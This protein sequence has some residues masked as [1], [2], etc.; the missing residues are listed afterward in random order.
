[1]K[2]NILTL[3]GIK[4]RPIL[5]PLERPV[6]AK[7]ATLYNW[8]LI[9]IDLQ[10]KEGIIGRSYLEPYVPKSMKYLVSALNDLSELF[11]GKPIFPFDMFEQARKSLHFVGYEG[12]SMIA[13]SGFDMAAWDA[14]ARTSDRPLCEFLGGS[15]APVAAYNSNGL[16][17]TDPELIGDE[18]QE[19]IEE[20]DFRALKLRMGRETI[21]EDVLALESIR[22]SIGEKIELMVD[23]NQGLNQSDALRRCHALDDMNLSWFEE[24]ILYDD[25]EG[26]AKLARELKTPLQIGENFYGPREMYKAIRRQA[27]DLVMPDFMRIGGISG[28]LRS[29]PIA[30]AAGIPVS[31][32][33][34]PEVAAHMMRI[35]ETAHW[36]EWQSWANPVLQQPYELSKGDLSI[37]DRPGLGLEWDEK[38]IQSYSI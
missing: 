15:R 16:W 38:V 23:F 9:L 10:T 18:A 2:N 36:L 8:P 7:I 14:L 22:K 3:K 12:L 26:Y 1:M 29:V 33:L 21:S 28:W 27:S 4:V 31:T 11:Q 34:Y 13:I 6:V 19:L 17:L 30:A 35:T 37:P 5:L 32:H 20:G 24:P 25:L